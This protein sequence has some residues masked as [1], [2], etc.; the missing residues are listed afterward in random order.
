MNN[1]LNKFLTIKMGDS[2]IWQVPVRTIA[3]NRASYYSNNSKSYKGTMEEHLK[4]KTIP[5]FN[6]DD[7]EIE[8]W[9]KNNMNWIDL[10]PTAKF[11]MITL[12]PS[13]CAKARNEIINK[14][15]YQDMWLDSETYIS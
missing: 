1:I 9:A 10:K 13:E 12:E 15:D 5:L 7:F 4:D 14:F 6:S 8:D 11:L 2:S 3:E